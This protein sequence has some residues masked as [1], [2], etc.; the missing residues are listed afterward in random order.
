MAA[1]CRSSTR[2][3]P[4]ALVRLGYTGETIEAI[5]EYIAEHGHVI[6]APALKPEHYSVFDCAMGE[7]AITPMGHV[8]MMAACQPFLSG[9][10]SKTVNMPRDGLGR[11]G[12][13][14][15]LPGVEDGHQGPGDLPGQLQ[16]GSA[17]VRCQGQEGRRR[18]A[19]GR[20]RVPPDPQAPAQVAAEPDGVVRGGWRRGVHDGRLLP[21]DGLGE[22]FLKLGKQGS[23]LAGVMDAFSIATSIALQYG[24]P[25]EAF[26]N[27]FVNMRFEPSGMTDDPDIRMAQSI[28]DYIFR[29]LALDYLDYDSREALG[30]FTAEERAAQVA[31]TYGGAQLEIDVEGLAQSVPVEEHATMRRVAHPGRRGAGGLSLSGV[32]SS[33]ELL[34]AINGKASDAPLCMTCG[35]KMRPAGSCYVCEG[36][37]STS[38][39]S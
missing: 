16:G 10:I 29:R 26:V 30:I 24:V 22:V 25:L 12:R 19:H 23:T 28:V 13:G 39:C 9:A 3:I 7:R 34:E 20:G 11:R 4:R 8:R 14:D 35:V 32:H 21:D 38:G 36:C 15:L 5:V 37:G 1:P 2:S 17:A 31:A 18:R 33:A 6:D 27:K